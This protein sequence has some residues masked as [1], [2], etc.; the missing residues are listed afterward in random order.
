MKNPEYQLYWEDIGERV[1]Y[2]E[3]DDYSW[4]LAEKM[5]GYIKQRSM[6]IY[7]HG[8]LAAF[9]KKADYKK[10]RIR[11]ENRQNEPSFIR[12]NLASRRSQ[13]DDLAS[14]QRH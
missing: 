3:L 7:H 5:F 2:A 8:R 12:F 9:Y 1:I 13:G 10:I 6:Y 14:E 11:S 4:K